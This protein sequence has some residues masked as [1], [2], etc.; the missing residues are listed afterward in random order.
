MELMFPSHC[1]FCGQVLSKNKT[2]C[3][4]CE[5]KLPW[6]Q[7]ALCRVGL[8]AL[9]RVYCAFDYDGRL[10]EGIAQFKFHG[11]SHLCRYFALQIMKHAGTQLK[12]EA[13]ERIVY[14]PMEGMKQQ[15]R[16]YNQA[17][18]LARELSKELGIPCSSC[19][20]KIRKTKTQHELSAKERQKAQ[21]GSYASRTLQGEKILLVDDICTTGATMQECARVLKEA[22]ASAVIGV[23][24][25]Q[26]AKESSL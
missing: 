13:C 5:E 19:L 10:P 6:T 18:L 23:A 3:Q 14:V 20:R 7:T 26:T 11:K 24:I 1:I 15:R 2:C 12:E 25:C 21:K 4:E 16:G 22:G 17:E 8:G 9:E